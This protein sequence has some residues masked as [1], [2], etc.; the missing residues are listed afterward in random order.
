MAE[1]E[2]TKGI[3]VPSSS[4]GAPRRKAA[5]GWPARDARPQQPGDQGDD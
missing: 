2:P 1:A 4:G 5:E 3:P